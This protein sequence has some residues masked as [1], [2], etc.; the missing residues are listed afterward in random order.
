M[1][2][3]LFDLAGAGVGLLLLSP[4]L[5]LISA[6]IK[7][8]SPGPVFY[9]Q[10]RVGRFGS[11]FRIHKFRTMRTDADRIGLPLTVGSDPRITRS[12]RFLRHYKLDELPQLIDVLLGKM[13]LVGPRPEV[14]KYVEHYPADVRALVLSVRPGITDLASIAYRDENALLG[15]STNP[16]RTYLE[17]V[18][19]A[20][21]R[22]NVE[23]ARQN[24]LLGDIK[25]IMRTLIAIVS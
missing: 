11:P 1:A 21:L 12:G 15:G 4:L 17:E 23:Y 24:N 10:V 18:L 7:L 9:R 13:S 2:K 3:R 6:W 25:I 16:D 14:P 22:F 8:D 20:K 5:L 19:P